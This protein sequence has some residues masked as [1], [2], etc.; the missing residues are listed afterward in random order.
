[1]GQSL[2]NQLSIT[3]FFQQPDSSLSVRFYL[4]EPVMF[5]P[6]A[7]FRYVITETTVRGGKAV[8]QSMALPRAPLSAQ[9][10]RRLMMR[11]S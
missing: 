9:M 7:G 6:E 10:F 8:R 2:K 4:V 1:M 5:D 3:E 11:K